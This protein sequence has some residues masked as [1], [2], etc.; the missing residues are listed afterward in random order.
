MAGNVGEVSVG[1]TGRDYMQASV[2]VLRLIHT[3][4]VRCD[5]IWQHIRRECTMSVSM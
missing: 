1:Q 3:D 4:V 2:D 5:A